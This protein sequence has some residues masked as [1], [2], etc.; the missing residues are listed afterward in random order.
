MMKNIAILGA[1]GFIGQAVSRF[2]LDT[3]K[4]NLFLA[5]Y[6][7]GKFNRQ[8]ISSLDLTKDRSLFYWLGE[9]KIDCI[10]YLSSMIPDSFSE[11]N[12]KS[13]SLNDQMHQQ[14]LKYWKLKRCHLI[15][16]SS[17]SVYG[18]GTGIPTKENSAP[19]PGNRYAVSKINGEDLFLK[20]YSQDLCP[21]TIL[22][23]NA[24]YGYKALRKT[25]VNI[26]MENALRGESLRLMGTGRR[27]QDFIYV[28]DVAL[29]FWL[30]FSKKK[31]G[32]YN[33]ASGRTV[34]MRQLAKEIIK[35]VHSSSEILFTGQPDP[36]EGY[37]VK[38]NTWRAKKE[39]NFKPQYNLKKGLRRLADLYRRE[40]ILK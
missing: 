5:S 29:A 36:Q 10:I 26:F 21:L 12:S 14:V 35:T 9:K 31:Y 7:G 24:P 33:I 28:D 25:V 40:G 30:A 22:R 6:K 4:A 17:C 34:T 20:E 32:I 1:T 27:R 15:Y 2:F 37:Q 11:A 3:R 19:L 39:L 8:I 38:I 16:A 13:Y 23:I 18:K